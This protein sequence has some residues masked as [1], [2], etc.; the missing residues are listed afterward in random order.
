MS[1]SAK[2]ILL[3][4]DETLIALSEK[5]DLEQVGY[6]VI[7][8][9]TGKSA[10]DIVNEDP[11]EIDL[12]LMDIDLGPG[13]DGTLA[14]QE[15]LRIH[16]IPIVFLS[17]H[18]ESEIVRK[19]EEITNYGYVVKSSS[20][21]VLDASIKMAFKLFGAMKQLDLD[22]MEIETANEELQR[23]LTKLQKA[24]DDLAQRRAM[25]E[26][27]FRLSP[28][29]ICITRL[30]DG[31]YMNVNQRF[32]RLFGFTR[33]ET[34]GHSC[35]SDDLGIWIHQEKREELAKRL[36]ENGEGL[37]LEM[38]FRRKDGTVIMTSTSADLISIDGEDC[39]ISDIRDI[40]DSKRCEIE[41]R[42]S[43]ERYRTIFE[44]AGAGILIYDT[45]LRILDANRRSVQMFDYSKE[46][47]CS[48]TLFDLDPDLADPKIINERVE[49]ILN[50]APYRFVAKRRRKDGAVHP[51]EV[52]VMPIV[53]RGNAAVM[54]II[55]DIEGQLARESELYNA[56][57]IISGALDSPSAIMMLGVDA[58]CRCLYIN[59]PYHDFLADRFGLDMKIGDRLLDDPHADRL[60]EMIQ[61][62]YVSAMAGN[63]VKA[64]EAMPDLGMTFALTANPILGNEGKVLGAS[65]FIVDISELAALERKLA[66]DEERFRLAMDAS[67][68]AIWDIDIRNSKAYFSPAY[69]P[70]LGYEQE[71]ALSIS[72]WPAFFHTNEFIAIGPAIKDC[73]ENRRQDFDIDY[74]ATLKNGSTRW[75]NICGKVVERGLDGQ[76]TRLL[77][78]IHDI[79]EKKNAEDVLR[80]K[81]SQLAS[82]GDNVPAFLAIL[83][84]ESLR[85]IYSNREFEE[86][87]GL[88]K[89]QILGRT[90]RDIAGEAN[91]ENAM[92]FLSKAL[93]GRRTSYERKFLL[94]KGEIWARVDYSPQFDINGK[95][96]C[97]L[98][99]G[100]DITELKNTTEA[101]EKREKEV[102]ELLRQKELTL[103]EVHHRINNNL[104]ILSSML[105][106][107]I[108]DSGDTRAN[109]VLHEALSEI[110][111]M[112]LLYDQL[113]RSQYTG[114]MSMREYF[115]QLLSQTAQVFGRMRRVSTRTEI[116][117]SMLEADRLSRL[118]IIIN[119]LMTN[120]IKYAFDDVADPAI[121]LHIERQDTQILIKYEDNG[122]GLPESFS[123]DSCGG[124]GM[125]LINAMLQQVGGTIQPETGR[126]A[127]FR[128]LLPA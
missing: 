34:I 76:A 25:Q 19:T 57:L 112:S 52:H 59:K 4:E 94:A 69:F 92:P 9:S 27:Y 89:E 63:K 105:S 8:S 41:L 28:D 90:I 117:D 36:H 99:L 35:L 50:S 70:M 1:N 122:R 64:I 22:S 121:S 91:Y 123:I 46:E 68:D 79:S 54:G 45:N 74:R 42:E 113:Y 2:N 11:A 84:G 40:S 127:R 5:R 96:E 75:I 3:V 98:I 107:R 12:I 109:T 51:V 119:E 83:D 31:V 15:I 81:E 71:E 38:D 72:A 23:N 125:L 14:A 73:I 111:S 65:L 56:Q 16:T 78:T 85:Y 114:C 20:F 128:I 77:G 58:D 87:Y 66:D 104:M 48:K 126:G 110:E 21:T 67:R 47:L 43:E 30:S 49:G 93:R 37:I 18:T 32:S 102:S 24:Y 80:E 103:R 101:L 120:S 115:S 106:I 116:D 7:L 95:V 13:M 60:L 124:F 33:E 100:V 108:D 61:I 55:H 62:H 6:K 97:V 53:W 86:L 88:T 29:A 17:A 82:I 44:E 10:I 118:G 39:I 26:K